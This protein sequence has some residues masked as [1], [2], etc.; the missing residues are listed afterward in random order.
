MP[1]QDLFHKA[2]ADRAKNHAAAGATSSEGVIAKAKQGKPKDAQ[3][4]LPGGQAPTAK[5]TKV[6]SK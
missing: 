1:K 5:V 2:E 3:P 6:G 4:E